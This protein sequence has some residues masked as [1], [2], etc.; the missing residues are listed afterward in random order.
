MDGIGRCEWGSDSV[1]HADGADCLPAEGVFG[2]DSVCLFSPVQPDPRV[3][4]RSAPFWRGSGSFLLSSVSDTV[5]ICIIVS[6]L[7]KHAIYFHCSTTPFIG[8][9]SGSGH[10]QTDLRTSWARSDE[11]LPITYSLHYYQQQSGSG[12]ISRGCP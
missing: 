4:D 12:R 3:W 10:G 1:E 7:T 11:D 8:K 5:A 2:L 9:T 6:F